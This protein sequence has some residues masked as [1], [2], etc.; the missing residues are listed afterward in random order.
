MGFALT[1]Q[2][3]YSANDFRLNWNL[4]LWFF[5]RG[6]KNQKTWKNPRGKE[7]TNNKLNPHLTPGPGIEP[8][9]HW[10]EASALFTAPPLLPIFL[11]LTHMCYE[12][13]WM[14]TSGKHV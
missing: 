6:R 13:R 3:G 2:S 11:A 9:P 1:P 8:G 5:F 14:K 12:L 10:W 4:E 7:R